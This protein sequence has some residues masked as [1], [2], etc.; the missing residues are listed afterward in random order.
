MMGFKTFYTA[1]QTLKGIEAM[2]MI[3][4]GQAEYN[5]SVLSAV[6]WLNKLFGIVSSLI[7]QF[8]GYFAFLFNSCTTSHLALASTVGFQPL[9]EPTGF[10]R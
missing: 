5:S 10:S 8:A 9:M 1:E 6:E 2:H 3:K 4:K 7:L